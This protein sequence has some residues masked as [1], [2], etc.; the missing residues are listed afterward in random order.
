[1]ISFD[2]LFSGLSLKGVFSFLYDFFSSTKL[3][4]FF[5]FYLF[6]L[7]FLGTLYQVDYGLYS[8]QQRYFYSWFFLIGG[9]VPLPSVK[10]VLLFFSINLAVTAY[11]RYRFRIEKMGIILI[12]YGLLFL[13]VGS[14]VGHYSSQESFVSLLEGE[15]TTFSE[16]YYNSEL[17]V[18]KEEPD[19]ENEGMVVQQIQSYDLK[20]LEDLSTSYGKEIISFK[21]FGITLEPVYYYEHAGASAVFEEGIESVSGIKSLDYQALPKEREQ[22][23]PGGVFILRAD[24]LLLDRKILL[25]EGEGAPYTLETSNGTYYIAIQRKRYEMPFKVKLRRFT[26]ELYYASDIPKRFESEVT[27]FK[28]GNEDLPA[29]IYMNHPLR[30]DGLTF[31]QASF[32]MERDGGK[33]SIFAVVDHVG[34]LVPYISSLIIALGMLYHFVYMMFKRRARKRS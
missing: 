2:K 26:R 9:F 10:L 5:L 3:A 31:F 28:E 15:E 7:T 25:W 27:V 30:L 1:M 22:I 19:K 8:A 4:V 13:L 12:H 29:R 23:L 6:L 33:R 34:Y 20:Y 14:F 17:V 18:W 16:D 32:A 11:R 21:D 24:F